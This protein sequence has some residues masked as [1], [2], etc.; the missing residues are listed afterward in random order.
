MNNVS[1]CHFGECYSI[2]LDELGFPFELRV[3]LFLAILMSLFPSID[4]LF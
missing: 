4:N 2:E 1:I 3:E